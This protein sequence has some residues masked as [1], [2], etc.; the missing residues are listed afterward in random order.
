MIEKIFLLLEHLKKNDL[1]EKFDTGDINGNTPFML[2]VR[3]FSKPEIIEKFASM[4]C[5]IHHQN[6]DGDNILHLLARKYKWKCGEKYDDIKLLVSLGVDPF[7][8]NHQKITPYSLLPKSTRDE[9]VL[10][11]QT[12][13]TSVNPYD[14]LMEPK[15]IINSFDMKEY[16]EE[17]LGIYNL[18]D[19][20]IC[21]KELHHDIHSCLKSV[22][23]L[24]YA[25]CYPQYFS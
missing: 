24:R 16:I 19:L 7:L 23:G 13:V 9:I 12:H 21:T 1:V 17:E 6:K 18:E 20:N 5:N 10:L 8:E 25:S 11:K 15:N 14:L 4:G 22:P 3:N 2:F